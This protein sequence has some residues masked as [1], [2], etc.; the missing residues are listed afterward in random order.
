MEKIDICDW[1]RSYL[2]AGPKPVSEIRRD[3][4]AAGYSRFE[5]REA[6]RLC[7]ITTTNNWT[8]EHPFT[9]EWYWELPKE[10]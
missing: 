1:L 5:L 3:A 8:P 4:N 9:D 10:E 2:Q 6:K 7:L